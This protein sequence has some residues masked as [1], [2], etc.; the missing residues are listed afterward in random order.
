[1]HGEDPLQRGSVNHWRRETRLSYT[2]GGICFNSSKVIPMTRIRMF[3][4]VLF[5]LSVFTLSACGA[6]EPLEIG[7]DTVIVDVRTPDEFASGHLDGAVN[8]DLNSGS[9][10]QQI[11]ELDPA[12]DYVVYCR[13]GNRSSQ[14]LKIM[15]G[16]GFE[17]VHDA[18]SVAAASEAT[19]LDVVTS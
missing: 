13:S 10:D 1:M 9:F 15:E 8:V 14:A 7:A 4:I 16:L 12:L 11:S 6:S 19:G 18:G 5:G 17:N 2:L 3:L